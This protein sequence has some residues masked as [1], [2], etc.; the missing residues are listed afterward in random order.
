MPIIPEINVYEEKTAPQIDETRA[1]RVLFIGA[2]D[3]EKHPATVEGSGTS[4]VYTFSPQ[5]I[6]TEDEAYNVLGT[7]T[8]TYPALK[9]IEPLFKGA[10][11]L[12]S[13]NMT[14]AGDTP[15]KT[16]NVTKLGQALNTVLLEKFDIIFVADT[17][18]D[19][20]LA[21]V[22][23]FDETRHEDKRPFD[24]VGVGTRTN[25]AAY[26]TNKMY[27]NSL[28][29][30]IGNI[31]KG[32]LVVALFVLL[33][34]QIYYLSVAALFSGAIILLGNIL[35]TKKLLP[36]IGVEIKSFSLPK[37]LSLI[38][39]GSWLL[40]SNI[41][42]LFLNGLDLLFSN[43]FISAAIMGRLSVSKQIPF[44][45]SIA[46]G[47]F[48]NI[49]SSS[50]TKVFAVSNNTMVANEAVS[51]LK[52]LTILFTVPYAVIIVFGLDFLSLWLGKTGYNIE[53]LHE[54]YYLMIIILL[55]IIISTYMYSIHSIFIA[56]DAVRYYSVI[57]FI[58]SCIS[59][60]ATLLLLQFTNLGVYAIA[61]TSTVILGVVHGIIVPVRAAKLQELP[62]SYYLKIEGESWLTFFL[63]IILFG[64]SSL[65]IKISGWIDFIASL[66]L[67]SSF[68]YIITIVCVIY[69]FNFNR[70]FIDL[71]KFL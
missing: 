39:S 61:G 16:I 37:V 59:V 24:Y 63:I 35:L 68:G 13:I 25:A 1:G 32:I 11:S 5:N 29:Q 58:S 10:T 15:D 46:L 7:D 18:S 28:V 60:V 36:N 30:I 17:I 43:W 70:L 45:M 44:A 65:F 3:A 22:K 14:V 38:K 64:L 71:K 34:P 42:N 41:S 56:M 47:S 12:L 52:I 26:T 20:L 8:T 19:E 67:L 69:R 31:V 48:S 33:P 53:Q 54:I 50:L 57:L 6:N 40:L 21:V 51:Q 23:A 49:F 4:A 66:L 2:F 55:D 27:Y 9:C 62:W